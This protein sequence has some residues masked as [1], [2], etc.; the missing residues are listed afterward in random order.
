MF[1]DVKTKPKNDKRYSD[2]FKATREKLGKL[3]RDVAKDTKPRFGEPWGLVAMDMATDQQADA[4][5]TIEW[6]GGKGHFSRSAEVRRG[7][8]FTV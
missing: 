7:S 5:V 2:E 8:Y 3:L 6:D 4:E 1:Q